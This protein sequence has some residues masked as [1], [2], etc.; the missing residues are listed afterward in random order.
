[1]SLNE[2]LKLQPC[3]IKQTHHKDVSMHMNINGILVVFKNT[4]IL[5]HRTNICYMYMTML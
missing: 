3:N 5:S 1:M 2:F 4:K